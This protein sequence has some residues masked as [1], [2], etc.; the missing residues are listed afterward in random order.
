MMCN[1][2][3]P[4]GGRLLRPLLLLPTL[5]AALWMVDLPAVAAAMNSIAESSLIAP[6]TD[7]ASKVIKSIPEPKQKASKKSNKKSSQPYMA[8]E[9]VAEFP[10]GMKAL[11][12]FM[13]KNIKYPENIGVSG[14]VIV[15]FVVEADGSIG[16]VSIVK[17]VAPELDAEAERVVKMMPRWIPGEV[18]GKPVA[19]YFNIP[20]NFE[21]EPATETTAAVADSG[22]I[23]DK[24]PSTS[25]SVSTSVSTTTTS[26]GNKETTITV[27]SDSNDD[28]YS[29]SVNSSGLKQNE[30]VVYLDGQKY[31][32]DFSDI[33]S[34]QIEAMSIEKHD[35]APSI[36]RITLKK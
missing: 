24:S 14:R 11:K 28:H 26:D 36:I 21:T 7:S 15:R 33:P 3:K 12:D 2:R 34:S 23:D 5:G 4:R 10:G 35:D 29:V 16:D 18:D 6:R 17:S 1:Q 31:E 9:K 8:V 27:T 13:K 32:G 22:E 19:S 30:Y 20:V 25:K